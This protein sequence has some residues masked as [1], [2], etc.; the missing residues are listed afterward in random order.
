MGVSCSVPNSIACD[1]VAIIV[2]TRRPA[3]AVTITI[4]G[5]SAVLDDLEWSQPW[6]HGVKRDFSG[7][8]QPAGLRGHGPLAVLVENHHNRWTGVHPVTAAL[9]VVITYA[10]GSR[11]ATS[12]RAPLSPGW[13]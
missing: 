1:R 12:A 2:A 6:R 7:F 13:G 5:R 9:H 4:G 11:R 8:L 3:R 10:D